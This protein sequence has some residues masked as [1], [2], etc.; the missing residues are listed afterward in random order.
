MIKNQYSNRWGQ[1]S[2]RSWFTWCPCSTTKFDPE[3]S[4]QWTV[5]LQVI[6]CNQ[7]K[8]GDGTIYSLFRQATAAAQYERFPLTTAVKQKKLVS[9]YHITVLR[10]EQM[11][12]PLTCRMLVTCHQLSVFVPGAHSPNP[13]AMDDL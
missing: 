6:V 9:K 10:A 3:F 1:C 12:V 8:V 4:L 5:L 13:Y 11:L 2:R 7:G